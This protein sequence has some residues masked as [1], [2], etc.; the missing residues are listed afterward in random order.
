MSV[1]SSVSHLV[2]LEPH[3]DDVAL[4]LGGWIASVA[5]AARIDVHVL[6]SESRWAPHLPE[7]MPI[8]AARVAE[9]QR[10]ADRFRLSYR[11][12]GLPDTSALGLDA[13]QERQTTDI[14][15]DWRLPAVTD[16]LVRLL[17]PGAFVLAPLGLG[18]HIDHRIVAESVRTT[19]SHCAYYEDLPYAC[20]VADPDRR[21]VAREVLSGEPLRW[22]FDMTRFV[23]V[24][25]TALALYAS[26]FTHDDIEFVLTHAIDEGG[27]PVER[28]W[29]SA[30]PGDGRLLES[31]GFSRETV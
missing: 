10:F 12:V 8:R 22:R 20:H 17:P 19:T 28:V 24:K 26:Q 1:A 3:P 25:R 21:E 18:N 14:T 7:H 29:T 15:R 9:G 6:F 11:D 16:A 31:L 13:I 4:S 2:I 27:T 5:G 30:R 23:E